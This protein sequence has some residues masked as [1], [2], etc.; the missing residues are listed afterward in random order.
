MNLDYIPLLP[1]QRDLQALPRNLERFRRYL[2]TISPDGANLELPSLVAANPMA[3][4][5]VTA[6]LDALLALDADG[7]AARAGA[8][9]GAQLSD[10]PGDFKV[11]LVVVDDLMGGWTNRYAEEFHWRFQVSPPPPGE[12]RVPRWTKFYWINGILWSSEAATE[13]TVRAA[14]L[15]AVYRAA[16]IQRHGPARTLRAMLIQ[17]GAV[18]ARAGCTGP[19]LDADDIAYTREVLTPFLDAQDKR[20]AIECLFGDAAGRTLGFTPRG[21]SPW[22]GLALALHDARQKSPQ[23]TATDG[24][25]TEHGS[26]SRH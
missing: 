6:L 23:K 13:Q 3:K 24:T 10:E 20:T 7:V 17:E 16:Y 15:T 5:H 22:A 26:E 19:V 25:R 4:E 18:M 12:L 11:A 8:E 21:L 1:I 9:A 14:I 2:R